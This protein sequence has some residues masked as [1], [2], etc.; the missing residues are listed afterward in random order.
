MG[1][2][3]NRNLATSIRMMAWERAKGELRGILHTYW[4][5]YYPDGTKVDEG[6]APIDKKVQQ[7]IKDL[8][9]LLL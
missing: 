9:D 3:S 5:S 6:F 8:D 2:V 7:F 1:D 4:P